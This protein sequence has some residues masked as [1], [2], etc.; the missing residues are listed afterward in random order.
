MSTTSEHYSVPVRTQPRRVRI[1]DAD[2]RPPRHAAE[3]SRLVPAMGRANRAPGLSIMGAP[4]RTP[5]LMGGLDAGPRVGVMGDGDRGTRVDVF[6]ESD[7]RFVDSLFT[8]ARY[9]R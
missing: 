1:R 3:G 7:L 9:V 2:Q 5:Y 4:S 8:S 6:G